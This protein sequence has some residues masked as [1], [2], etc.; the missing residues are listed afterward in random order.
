MFNSNKVRSQVLTA[1]K[2]GA[3][4]HKA[5][6]L[7]FQINIIFCYTS[8]CVQLKMSSKIQYGVRFRV[9]EDYCEIR[10][11][12]VGVHTPEYIL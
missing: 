8:I 4:S 6:I 11:T 3:A 2:L 5:V 10:Q 1:A 9:K 7:I 12:F